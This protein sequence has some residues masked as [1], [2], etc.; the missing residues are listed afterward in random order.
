MNYKITSYRKALD[1][2]LNPHIE[3]LSEFLP[4]AESRFLE[5]ASTF[6]DRFWM[7]GSEYSFSDHDA[8]EL[9]RIWQVYL[10]KVAF[11]LD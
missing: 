7:L 10:M 4:A 11:D 2:G 8:E 6:A 5:K 1:G 9:A 3:V